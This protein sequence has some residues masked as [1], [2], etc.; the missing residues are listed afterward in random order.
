MK[1]VH[2][3]STLCKIFLKDS[4]FLGFADRTAKFADRTLKFADRTARF[5][6]GTPK[7]ADRRKSIG[8]K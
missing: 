6:D 7:F 4:E 3:Y 8:K 1:M 2:L 5:A